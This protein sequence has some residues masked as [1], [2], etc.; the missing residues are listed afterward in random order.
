MDF[1]ILKTFQISTDNLNNLKKNIKDYTSYARWHIHGFVKIPESKKFT[2]IELKKII[3]ASWSKTNE[4]L[5]GNF[6][7]YKNCEI[8]PLYDQTTWLNYIQKQ[9][10]TTGDIHLLNASHLNVI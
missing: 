1:T 8:G 9:C 6:G 4:T 2:Y 3:M 5:F 10:D 7:S